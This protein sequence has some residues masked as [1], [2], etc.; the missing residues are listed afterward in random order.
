MQVFSYFCFYNN[1]F[2]QTNGEQDLSKQF[3]VIDVSSFQSVFIESNGGT[4]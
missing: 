4:K 1:P 2:S 3:N